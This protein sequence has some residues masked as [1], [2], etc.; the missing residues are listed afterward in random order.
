MEA[1]RKYLGCY[2]IGYLD[3]FKKEIKAARLLITDDEIKT[4]KAKSDDKSTRI[5]SRAVEKV[6]EELM[7]ELYLSTQGAGLG[8]VFFQTR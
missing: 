2:Q 4:G 1:L 3:R 8:H 6:E 7:S 5:V